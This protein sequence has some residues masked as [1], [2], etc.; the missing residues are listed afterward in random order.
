MAIG[1]NIV[2]IGQAAGSTMRKEL[3]V[4]G[5]NTMRIVSI[6]GYQIGRAGCEEGRRLGFVVCHRDHRV[7][8]TIPDGPL[9]II[10]HN[11]AIIR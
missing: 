9:S 7:S 2:R 4:R 5:R 3:L 10:V 1:R 11:V 8:I 6:E